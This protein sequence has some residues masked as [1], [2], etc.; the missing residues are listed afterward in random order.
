MKKL[1]FTIVLSMSGIG[2]FAQDIDFGVKAGVNFANFSGKNNSS[3]TT[4]GFYLGGFAEIDISEKFQVQ[5]ELLYSSEGASFKVGDNDPTVSFLRLPIMAKYMIYE[6]L[7]LVAGPQLGVMLD[8]KNFDF[9][10]FDLGLGT[11]LAYELDNGLGFDLRYNFGF[12]NLSKDEGVTLNQNNL[13][14]GLNYE[15]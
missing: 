4:T 5:P 11:G 2:A 1:I 14:F 6:N 3:E 12:M 9:N 7:D 10:T 13:M 15:F 8:D